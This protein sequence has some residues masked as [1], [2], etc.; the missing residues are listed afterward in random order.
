MFNQRMLYIGGRDYFTWTEQDKIQKDF[1]KFVRDELKNKIQ[2]LFCKGKIINKQSV[3]VIWTV[4]RVEENTTYKF[5]GKGHLIYHY[6]GTTYNG[7]N[8]VQHTLTQTITIDI[9][10]LEIIDV[11]DSEE[12]YTLTV[13]TLNTDFIDK[14]K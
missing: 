9:D 12:R 5:N 2:Y 4:R 7:F 6:S 8:R 10:N 11:N 3:K 13:T 14:L 1:Q